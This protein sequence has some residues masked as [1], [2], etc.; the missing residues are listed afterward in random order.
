M[1]FRLIFE[2]F[3]INVV[4]EGGRGLDIPFIQSL[5]HKDGDQL[6]REWN[7]TA[8]KLVHVFRTALYLVRV[9]FYCESER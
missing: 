3:D 4:N 7:A 2:S 6:K 5:K 8:V 9:T 1:V